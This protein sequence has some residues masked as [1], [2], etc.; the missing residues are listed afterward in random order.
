M[1]NYESKD[2]Y[3]HKI[4]RI[5]KNYEDRNSNIRNDLKKVSINYTNPKK[6][7]IILIDYFIVLV[8]LLNYVNV[9]KALNNNINSAF[10][11]SNYMSNKNYNN[12]K[13]SKLKSKLENNKV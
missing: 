9:A 11:G 3:V 13:N 2:V 1:K 5:L 4:N 10:S 12:L 8:Y 6:I 7:K